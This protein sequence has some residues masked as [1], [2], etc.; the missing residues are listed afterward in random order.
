M[1]ATLRK[2]LNDQKIAIEYVE[3]KLMDRFDIGKPTRRK[4][5]KFPDQIFPTVYFRG[6][7]IDY[8]VLYSKFS[9]EFFMASDAAELVQ[10]HSNVRIN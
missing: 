1:P 7:F 5:G 3:L 2:C 6:L 9:I 4:M 8:Y 10:A